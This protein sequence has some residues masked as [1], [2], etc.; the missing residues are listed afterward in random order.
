MVGDKLL[1]AET[2]QRVGGRGVLVRSGYGREEERALGGAPTDRGPDHVC[3][4]LAAASAWI[5]AA[6]ESPERG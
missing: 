1:D 6:L 2:A 4:G 5:L 3:D